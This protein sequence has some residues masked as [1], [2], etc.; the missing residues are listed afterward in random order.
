MAK[1]L[2]LSD[3]YMPL[4]VAIV[5]ITVWQSLARQER[6]IFYYCIFSVILFAASNVI[7]DKGLH[8]M[9]LYHIFSLVELWFISFYILKKI[10]GKNYSPAFIV[11]NAG[12][13]IF[14]VCNVIFWE[15]WSLFNSNSAGAA[16]LTTLFLCM[17]YLLKL[18]KN[19]EILY[20]QRLPSFWIVSG[21]LIYNAVS[22]L[23]LL[24][25]K[26]FTYINMPNLGDNL[27]FVLSA[28]NIVKFA[29]ISTGLLCHRK[30]PTIHSPFL[31]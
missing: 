27:W 11:I 13:I 5:F 8:N 15:D 14:F 31:L 28:A 7:A 17:F 25:Y 29:L 4:L 24:S 3:T 6:T 21:F 1:L 20:F 10:T 9:P 26:Y 19:D 22:V 2:L 30:R 18:S 12:Y 16:S 23:V